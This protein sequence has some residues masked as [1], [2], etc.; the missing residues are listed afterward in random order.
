MEHI[1]DPL[2]GRNTWI[3]SSFLSFTYRGI[4]NLNIINKIKYD[5]WHLREPVTDIRRNYRFF[6]L[7]NK[8]DY[9]LW[10]WKL[11]IQPRIKNEF[12][13]E[14]P[15]DLTKPER[16]E[17]TLLLILLGK[18]PVLRKSEI[19]LGLEY[20]IFNQLM[21]PVPPGLSDDY[22]GLVFAVQFT[23]HVDY[24][25]YRLTTQIGLRM[26]RRMYKAQTKTSMASFVTV[27]AGAE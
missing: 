13:R 16:K 18:F 24:L 22:R 4:K 12:R 2:A 1:S 19:E 26:D 21:D 6:G 17:D 9:T 20:T 23:N 25:G 5:W 14:V 10:L 15:V 8:A 11:R 27:Y 7:I 3:N